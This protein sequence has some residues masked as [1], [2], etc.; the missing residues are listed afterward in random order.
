MRTYLV[1]FVFILA[2]LPMKGQD[3]YH[4]N[5]Q[6]FL[7]TDFGLPTA[8]YVYFDNETDN[9]TSSINYGSSSNVQSISDQDFTQIAR[10]NVPQA[11]NQ[12]FDAG[13]FMRNPNA[14]QQGDVLLAVFHIRAVGQRGK[15][16]FFIENAGNFTKEIF[17]TMPVDTTWRRFLIPFQSSASYAPNGLS[18]GFHLG[19][20]A[21]NLEIGGITLLNYAN[22]APLENL[23]DETNNEF[24]EGWE[25]DAPWRAE[26]A[27][28]IDSLRKVSLQINL[29]D[30]I[31]NPLDNASVDIQML[32]HEFAFGTAI[33]ANRIAGNNSQ[34][35]VYEDKLLNLDGEGHGFNWVVFENDMKWPAWENAW[36]VNRTELVN[37]VSWLRDKNIKI[38]G[39]N[40]VWPGITNL[41]D[42]IGMNINDQN[43]IK[44]RIDNHLE[45]ILNWPGMQGQIAEWDVL[46]EIITNTSLENSFKNTPGYTTGRELYAEIFQKARQEDSLTGLWL[47]DFITLSLQ[48]E[49]GSVQYDQYK[50]YIQ[51]LL[52]AQVDLEGIG[53]QAHIGGF[54]NGIPSVLNTLDDFYNSFG[55]K[56]KITE[57]DT[58]TFVKESLGATYLKDILTASFSHPSV[59]GFFF[60]NFWDGA[61]WQNAGSNLFRLDWSMTPAG[62]AYVDLLFNEWWTEERLTSNQ[63]GSAETRA[64]K[65]LYEISYICDGQLVR[66]TLN[67]SQDTIINISCDNIS[68]RLAPSQE[69]DIS[70][71]P[72]PS[73]G[74]IQIQHEL[75]EEIT[76]QIDNLQGQNVHTSFSRDQLLEMKLTD[77]APGV[78]VIR[79]DT[80]KGWYREK[81][82]L[83]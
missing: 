44:S 61:F 57:F 40:L 22:T 60:W 69:L 59:D 63:N 50:A 32:E 15:V 39:H 76:I 71:F 26:A 82:I 41:P 38:R 45:S 81:L 6:N 48:Q 79:I 46:N 73:K 5:L 53:F 31:G 43:F 68:T 72:N 27:A 67:L 83:R 51:E 18:M 14:V 37:A 74:F 13:W 9:F 28:R 33:T 8:S 16:S 34:N 70:V 75:L 19:F 58:P 78:Y 10:I 64:F 20:Q 55:L 25:A 11:G 54:P 42:D 52:D 35:V 49:A 65:G 36:F 12:S 4:S 21:Q 66:D 3:S 77:I 30:Q 7:Q 56:A 24:Y 47:N 2:L 80:E 23:P 29:S 17:L 1:F 62:E